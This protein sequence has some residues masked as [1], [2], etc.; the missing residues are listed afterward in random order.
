M[1]RGRGGEGIGGEEKKR[2]GRRHG[3]TGGALLHWLRGIDAPVPNICVYANR[4]GND[5]RQ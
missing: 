3:R 1:G 2:R 4:V 5:D